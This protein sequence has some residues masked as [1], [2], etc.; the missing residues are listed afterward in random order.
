MEPGPTMIIGGFF[1]FLIIAIG[2]IVALLAFATDDRPGNR[3]ANGS[4]D[5]DIGTAFYGESTGPITLPFLT[6]TIQ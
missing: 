6:L 5:T 4:C 3:S 1:F 2:F